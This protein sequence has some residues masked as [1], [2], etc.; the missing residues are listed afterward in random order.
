[1][2][3]FVIEIHAPMNVI[4]FV[5]RPIEMCVVVPVDVFVPGCIAVVCVERSVG[6]DVRKRIAHCKAANV[7]RALSA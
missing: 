2:L 6:V 5:N 1:M 7:S 3:V 4:V